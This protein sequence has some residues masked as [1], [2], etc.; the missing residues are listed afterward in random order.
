MNFKNPGRIDSSSSLLPPTCRYT[1]FFVGQNL[2]KK[3]NKICQKVYKQILK[4]DLKRF[5]DFTFLG[6]FRVNQFDNIITSIASNSN[7]F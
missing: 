1:I 7:N 4:N 3:D 2:Y 6:T 5:L